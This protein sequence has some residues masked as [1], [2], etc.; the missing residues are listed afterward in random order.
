MEP[1]LPFRA[2]VCIA[3]TVEVLAEAT[4]P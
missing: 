2:E 4:V 1:C 3:R